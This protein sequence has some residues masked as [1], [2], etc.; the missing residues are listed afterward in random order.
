M[1]RATAT[2]LLHQ[3]AMITKK[4]VTLYSESAIQGLIGRGNSSMSSLPNTFTH[5]T[6]SYPLAMLMVIAVSIGI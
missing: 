3:T 4:S 1:E 2:R 6:A 5:V